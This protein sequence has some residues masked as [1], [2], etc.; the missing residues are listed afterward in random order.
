MLLNYY[1]RSNVT[2]SLWLRDYVRFHI[3]IK[4]RLL[5]L[6]FW[7]D[8]CYFY[9]ILQLFKCYGDLHHGFSAVTRW[10]V[11]W[12]I[13]SMGYFLFLILFATCVKGSGRIVKTR[14][15]CRCKA[16]NLRWF[17]DFICADMYINLYLQKMG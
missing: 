17:H 3:Y 5:N 4:V 13:N 11:F 15:E 16:S 2:E 1:V 7:R 9:F 12:E 14:R 6:E 8:I 10:I